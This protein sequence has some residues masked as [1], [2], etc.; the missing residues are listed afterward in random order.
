MTTSRKHEHDLMVLTELVDQI[1]TDFGDSELAKDF[2]AAVWLNQWIETPQPSLALKTPLDILAN[3]DGLQMT[4]NLLMR[5]AV[6][7]FA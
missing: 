5:I 7:A 1:V 6:S 3:P 2:D 4:K